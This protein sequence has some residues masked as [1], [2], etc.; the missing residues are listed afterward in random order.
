MPTAPAELRR[1]W[2]FRASAVLLPISFGLYL[3]SLT[4]HVAEVQR[5][6]QVFGIGRTEAE[7]MMLLTTIRDLYREGEVFLAAMITAFTLF[8][9]ISKYVAL[10]Y[11]MITRNVRRRGGFLS[12]I[13]NLG[14]WS[15]GDVFVVALLVVTMRLN[16]GVAQVQIVILP[17]LWVF[18]TSV[19]L[20]MVVSALL[21][22]LYRGQSSE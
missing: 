21:G 10:G 4:M 19:L 16:N 15:M 6:L 14:Q 20:S 3:T 9:P 7:S 2:L 8:F 12:A 11:V 18:A 1:S 22:F 17:G 13:K 5:T